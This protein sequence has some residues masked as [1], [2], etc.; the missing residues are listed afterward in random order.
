[1]NSGFKTG[2]IL[3]VSLIIAAVIF[4]SY[5]YRAQSPGQTITV[6]GAASQNFEADTVK[7]TLNIEEDILGENLSAGYKRLKAVRERIF[8]LLET[9]GIGRDCVTMKPV[10]VYKEYDYTAEARI[11]RGYRFQQTLYVITDQV[12]MVEKMASD[13]M[14]LL[15]SGTINSHLEYFYSGLDELKKE[16]VGAATKNARER[17]EKMVE[18]T[19]VQVGKIISVRSGV[20]QITEPNSTRVEAA[21]IHDTSTRQQQIRVTAHATFT[22]K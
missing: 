14:E 1:M 3:G 9:K 15:N 12:D 22:L 18:D 6:V 17:A 16:L 2:L 4:G 20:F 13:P 21:G 7:W 19:D 8:S 10:Q 11:F 5:F